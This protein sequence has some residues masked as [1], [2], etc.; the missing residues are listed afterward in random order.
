MVEHR[1]DE[2]VTSL[3][4]FA[5]NK[6]P[7]EELYDLRK[8]P[9]QTNNLAG[10]PEYEPVRKKLRTELMGELKVNKDPRI[11]NDAFDQAPYLSKK[12]RRKNSK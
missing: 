11:D 2:N 8:D 4:D 10:N 5:W 9:F 12:T 3:L 1:N 6:R 7:A